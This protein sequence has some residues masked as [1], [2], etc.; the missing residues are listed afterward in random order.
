MKNVLTLPAHEWVE[1]PGPGTRSPEHPY[2][3]R[4]VFL[5]KKKKKHLWSSSA[6]EKEKKECLQKAGVGLGLSRGWRPASPPLVWSPSAGR[7]ESKCVGSPP[8]CVLPPKGLA[9]AEGCHRT[10]S[11]HG[12]TRR[13]WG[14]GRL[15]RVKREGKNVESQ[16]KQPPA[17]YW[18]LIYLLVCVVGPVASGWRGKWG[19][20]G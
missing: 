18:D 6:S 7:A 16:S 14:G 11:L 10:V 2:P 9:S 19:G 17:A 5:K 3:W 1:A 20:C 15:Q 13:R 4:C 12:K 8:L